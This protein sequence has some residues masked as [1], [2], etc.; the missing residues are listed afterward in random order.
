MATY[1][2]RTSFW[3]TR[4]LRDIESF[5]KAQHYLET[6]NEPTED[7]PSMSYFFRK[8]V[9]E[10]AR[11]GLSI[12]WHLDDAMGGH[13]TVESP[14]ELNEE[15]L[16]EISKEISGQNS[17]GLGEGFEQ[18]EF[19][20]S[21][22]T[23]EDDPYDISHA[24]FYGWYDSVLSSFDWESNDYPLILQEIREGEYV[25]ITGTVEERAASVLF[26]VPDEEIGVERRGDQVRNEP[27]SNVP[28]I[29]ELKCA[30]RRDD[31]SEQAR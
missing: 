29:W 1:V 4:P 12:S 27:T 18:C 21:P 8:H 15:V 26:P 28:A 5:H 11:L 9:K 30:P 17:D 7:C 2:Y 24:E 31:R 3:L 20:V 25:P 19:A 13:I 10:A 22:A 6:S 23:E 14:E 16:S